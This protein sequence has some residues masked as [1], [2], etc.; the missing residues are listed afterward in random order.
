L[1]YSSWDSWAK[2]IKAYTISDASRNLETK[3]SPLSIEDL[4]IEIVR[5]GSSISIG[6]TLYSCVIKKELIPVDIA[7]RLLIANIVIRKREAQSSCK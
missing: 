4:D 7:V 1:A 6:S 5:K 2:A 3:A